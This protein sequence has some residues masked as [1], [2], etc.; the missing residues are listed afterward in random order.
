MKTQKTGDLKKIPSYYFFKK[1]EADLKNKHIL[2]MNVITVK[3]REINKK[4]SVEGLRWKI[5]GN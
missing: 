2:D 3:V 1:E 4:T 5:F